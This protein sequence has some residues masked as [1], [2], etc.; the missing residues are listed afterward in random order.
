MKKRFSRFRNADPR[1]KSIRSIPPRTA[2]SYA[3]TSNS[4]QIN[5]IV[6]QDKRLQTFTI[7]SGTGEIF[8]DPVSKCNTPRFPGIFLNPASPRKSLA[9]NFLRT[10]EFR[11]S[12][13]HIFFSSPPSSIIHELFK[14]RILKISDRI[15]FISRIYTL[16]CTQYFRIL[17]WR[18]IRNFNSGFR[19][20]EEISL[21]RGRKRDTGSRVKAW[22]N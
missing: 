21:E 19:N 9:D 7:R 6:F 2:A 4:P 8:I 1:C 17:F 3:D 14:K 13:R 5:C 15:D 20:F 18:E 22:S 11:T 10:Q 12:E 16:S